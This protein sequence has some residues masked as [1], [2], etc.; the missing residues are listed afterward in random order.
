MG[1]I[2]LFLQIKITK[3]PL[4]AAAFA[5]VDTWVNNN[6]ITKIPAE[7]SIEDLHYT[8]HRG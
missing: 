7:A 3:T 8:V 4:D 1:D 5:S 6:I 2:T